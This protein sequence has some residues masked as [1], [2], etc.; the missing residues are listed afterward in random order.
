MYVTTVLCM[1]QLTGRKAWAAREIASGEYGD[2]WLS[3]FVIIKPHWFSR[4]AELQLA[5]SITST[6]QRRM[7]QKSLRDMGF[8]SAWGIRDGQLKRYSL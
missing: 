2:K 8:T 1:N 6:K 5:E 4:D 7:M 3:G